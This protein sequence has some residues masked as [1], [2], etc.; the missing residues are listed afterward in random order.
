M[1]LLY[2][3]ES[4]DT[5][6]HN[7]ENHTFVLCGL[8]VHHADWHVAQ[9]AFEEMRRRMER[10]FGLPM[11]AEIHA[12]E[13]LGRS[14]YHFGLDR[15][16]RIKAALHQVDM[17]RRQG[18][19]IGI[20]VIIDKRS[21]EGDVMMTAWLQM[22]GAARSIALSAGHTRCSSPGIMVICDDHRTAPRQQLVGVRQARS[23]PEFR[24]PGSAIRARLTG[25]RLPA[26][27]RHAGLPDETGVRTLRFLLPESFTLAH[28]AMRPTVRRKGR[29]S[30]RE[31]ERGR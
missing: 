3:D 23:G 16:K 27:L 6:R 25:Q 15:T 1:H 5:G 18:T 7:P 31:R 24:A 4:G 28:R 21:F 22:L 9:G 8:L 26:S 14:P 29:D 11:A 17:I 12:S 2:V 19:L 13:L 30:L 20:R 10:T